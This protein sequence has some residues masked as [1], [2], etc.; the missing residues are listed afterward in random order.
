VL[1]LV[2]LVLVHGVVRIGPAAPVCR[3]G[4]PCDRPASHVVLRFTSGPRSATTRTD[5]AGRYRISLAPGSW[6]VHASVGRAIRPQR[7]VVANVRNA[8]RDIVIDSGIR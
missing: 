3:V 4:V 6:T 2:A 7:F 5:A 8:V 1:A